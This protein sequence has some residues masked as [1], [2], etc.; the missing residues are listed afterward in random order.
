MLKFITLNLIVVVNLKLKKL[1]RL[2]VIILDGFLINRKVKPMRHFKTYIFATLVSISSFA[3]AAI[4]DHSSGAFFSDGDSNLDW[5]DITTTIDEGGLTPSL[6][7]W[8]FATGNEFNDLISHY[9]ETSVT[10]TSTTEFD[11][12]KQTVE[13]KQD[14]LN[15][16]IYLFTNDTSLPVGG[17]TTANGFLT[18]FLSDLAPDVESLLTPGSILPARWTASIYFSNAGDGAS[19]Y[20]IAHDFAHAKNG[21]TIEDSG[22]VGQFL[23]RTSVASNTVPEPSIIALFA[24]GFLGLGLSRRKVHRS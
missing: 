22:V 18:G 6:V 15:D 2:G 4:I 24:L 10:A 1:S 12:V 17:S 5:L 8:R 14:K 11:I 16:L 13:E 7:G 23:V 3:Q 20:T 9:T 19:N 21:S